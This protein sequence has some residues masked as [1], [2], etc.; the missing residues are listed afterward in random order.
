MVKKDNEVE[1]CDELVDLFIPK[2]HKTD[3]QRFV[4]VNGERILIKT[5]VP[6]KVKRKFAEVIQNSI[7]AAQAADAY[8]EAN[9]SA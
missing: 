8:I 1:Y 5:G 2:T 3:T 4:S 6:V 9:M 7:S